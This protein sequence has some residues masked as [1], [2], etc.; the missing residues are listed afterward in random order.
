MSTTTGVTT[1][2]LG[3]LMRDLSRLPAEAEQ[4]WRRDQSRIADRAVGLVQASALGDSAQAALVAPGIH[5]KKGARWPQI[6]A[7]T[8]QR[9]PGAASGATYADVFFGANWG[10]GARPTTRQFRRQSQR[11]EGDFFFSGGLAEGIDEIRDELLDTLD[12]VIVAFNRGG[13]R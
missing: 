7:G 11:G 12:S 8:S 4:A 2:G 13:D 5:A 10:G 3:A 6:V 1:P 9:I